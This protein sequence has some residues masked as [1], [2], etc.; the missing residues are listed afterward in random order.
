MSSKHARW[1]DLQPSSQG[2]YRF[3]IPF[4]TVTVDG[5]ARITDSQYAESVKLHT[6]E[7]EAIRQLFSLCSASP[8]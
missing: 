8:G 3:P 2:G 4:T 7:L 1:S 6:N 5:G